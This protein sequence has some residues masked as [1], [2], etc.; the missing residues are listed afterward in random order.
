MRCLGRLVLL[1][2]LIVAAAIAWL[3]RD[4]LR[5]WVDSTLHPAAAMARVGHPSPAALTAAN[6]KLDGLQ[7]GRSDSVVLT[8]NEMASLLAH[9]T[10]LLPGSAF[11]SITVELG[12]RSARIRTLLDSAAIPARIRAMIPGGAHRYEE[13]VLSGS[14][15]PVRAGVAEMELQHVTV[16]GVPLP[17][18]VVARL[19]GEATGRRSD[20]RI[21]VT[22]PQTVSGFRVR[23]EGVAVYR[24]GVHP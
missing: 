4:D 2:I 3:Y 23:P 16:R 24:P 1:A 20:N 10:S 11:D 14:L 5:R 8:A 7:R 18:D 12:D 6:T 15:T 22:L 17:S 13:L 9:G 19:V 21:E